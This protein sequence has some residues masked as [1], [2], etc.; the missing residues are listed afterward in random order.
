MPAVKDQQAA[1]QH[2]NRI[3]VPNIQRFHK[4]GDRN[5]ALLIWHD[6]CCRPSGAV[7]HKY[8]KLLFPINTTKVAAS[9]TVV[10]ESPHY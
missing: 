5:I 10:Q 2:S 8:N 6:G 4:G 9:G 7:M 3:D 1:A